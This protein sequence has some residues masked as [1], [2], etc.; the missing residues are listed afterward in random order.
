ML[1]TSNMDRYMA[2]P[3]RLEPGETAWSAVHMALR[4]PYVF[5]TWASKEADGWLSQSVILW[6]PED[7]LNCCIDLKADKSRKILDLAVLLPVS[8]R[9][10]YRWRWIPVKEVW[11]TRLSKEAYAYPVYVAFD[12]ER[13]GGS[14][15]LGSTDTTR[16]VIKVFASTKRS[17]NTMP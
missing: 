3:V 15:D 14:G 2:V 4:V 10:T 8:V 16:Q 13:I 17:T 5:I 6:R 9:R 12:G 1:T 11:A 7:V